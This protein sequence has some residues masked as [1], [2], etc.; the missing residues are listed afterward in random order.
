MNELKYKQ[1]R[2]LKKFLDRLTEELKKSDDQMAKAIG[3]T[4]LSMKSDFVKQME[5][6]ER[7]REDFDHFL[8]SIMLEIES[9]QHEKR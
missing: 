6:S 3:M 9:Y 7:M 5:K 4:V 8:E 1:S 2:L